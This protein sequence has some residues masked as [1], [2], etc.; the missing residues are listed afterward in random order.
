MNKPEFKL[1]NKIAKITLHAE[2]RKNAIDRKDLDLMMNFLKKI[3][4]EKVKCLILSGKGDVFSSGMYLEELN[5]GDWSKNPISEVCD[6]IEKLPFITICFLNGGIYGGSVELA[7]SCDFRIGF[8]KV[9]IKIPA[10]KFG[11]H[12]GVKGIKRCL[13]I[14]GLQLS[15]KLLFLGHPL[16]FKDLVDVGFLDYYAEDFDASHAILNKIIGE[17]SLLSLEALRDMKAT[18]NDLRYNKIDDDKEKTRFV[19]GFKNGIVATRLQD[20]KKLRKGR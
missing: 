8:N 6:L 9:K 10:T 18:L 2:D 19:R 15:R 4:N 5:K 1:Q 20:Y 17:I 7:L 12:Y 14:F 16:A 13:E 3:E 11:I